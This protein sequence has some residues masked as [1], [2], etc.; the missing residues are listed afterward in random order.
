MS[1]EHVIMRI[2]RCATRTACS[3]AVAQAVPSPLATPRQHSHTLC[4][5]CG[6]SSSK[7]AGRDTPKRDS[8]HRGGKKTVR[9]HASTHVASTSARAHI[10]SLGVH[11]ADASIG[12]VASA[13]TAASTVS[14]SRRCEQSHATRSSCARASA[15]HSMGVLLPAV[16]LAPAVAR[17]AAASAAMTAAWGVM[18]PTLPA[19]V[20]PQ[21]LLG[22]WCRTHPLLH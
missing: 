6:S 3:A 8:G 5:C 2:M 22:G 21:D 13:P 14:R 15:A 4:S 1:I 18:L 11:E 7:G 17:A 19:C 10:A 16:A 12:P 20:T 9:W